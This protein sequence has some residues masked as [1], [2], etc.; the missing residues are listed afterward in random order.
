[1]NIQF[2][3]SFVNQDNVRVSSCARFSNPDKLSIDFIEVVVKEHLIAGRY[4]IAAEGPAI[5][6]WSSDQTDLSNLNP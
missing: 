4:L 1:M 5:F 6:D 2:N 3:F